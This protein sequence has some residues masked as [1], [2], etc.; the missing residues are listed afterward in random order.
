[1][2]EQKL[3]IYPHLETIFE[4]ASTKR[5]FCCTA[6]TGSG[7]STMIP[8][9]IACQGKTCIV[10]TPTVT[11]ARQLSKFVGSCHPE[12]P[13]GFAGGGEVNYEIGKHKIVY[14]TAGHVYRLLMRDKDVKF[15]FLVMDEAHTVSLDYNMLEFVIKYIWKGTD[16]HLL[17]ASATLN[18]EVIRNRWCTLQSEIDVMEVNVPH[19]PVTIKYHD[20]MLDEKELLQAMV[21]KIVEFNNTMPPGHFLV[22][23][24]GTNLI[25]KMYDMLYTE[26]LGLE[27]ADVFPA[28]SSLP[29]EEI[30]KAVK[31]A[32][33]ILGYRAIILATDMLETSITVENV[34][35]VLDS[36]KQKIVRSIPSDPM[37]TQLVEEYTSQFSLTQRAGRT[38][39]TNPGTV[40]RMFTKEYE[41]LNMRLKLDREIDRVPLFSVIIYLFGCKMDPFSIIPKEYHIKI[42]DEIEYL[43]RLGLVI[44]DNQIS[45]DAEYVMKLPVDLQF[46]V[47]V[48]RL[49]KHSITILLVSILQN[50]SQNNSIHLLPRKERGES[51]SDFSERI[52]NHKDEFYSRFGGDTDISNMMNIMCTFFEEKKSFQHSQKKYKSGHK[53]IPR[54]WS[55]QKWCNQNKMNS[56]TVGRIARMCKRLAEKAYGKDYYFSIPKCR[57]DDSCEKWLHENVKVIQDVLGDGHEFKRIHGKKWSNG[58]LITYFINGGIELDYGCD[59]VIAMCKNHVAKNGSTFGYLSAIIPI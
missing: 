25:N 54:Q 35:L 19:Y 52:I 39:R 50:I 51:R 44:G 9:T 53:M 58:S 22:F 38:G 21:D 23:L 26:G 18:P 17:I 29:K 55:D 5:V 14:A 41:N 4:A 32:K 1:M 2:S 8:V 36:G 10:T 28:Y 46:G 40:Y 7:K 20:R 48:K 34:C 45:S 43:R 15:D 6:D 12:I 57:A 3:P 49:P 27:N 31:P 33:P 11:T 30:D 56:K 42:K 16:F 59:R 37:S 13:V 47:L 24:P